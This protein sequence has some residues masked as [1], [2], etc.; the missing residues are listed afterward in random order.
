V[1]RSCASLPKEER[2]AIEQQD[3]IFGFLGQSNISAKNMARLR[4]LSS[5]SNAETAKLAQV[6]LEVALVKP[7]KRRRI[8][9]LAKTN[10]ELLMKLEETGLIFA[11]HVQ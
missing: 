3:E 8:K 11:H 5:S 1:C 7:H 2:E 9:F 6:A 10:R 4:V